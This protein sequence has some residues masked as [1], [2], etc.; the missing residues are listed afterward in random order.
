[1]I[2]EEWKMDLLNRKNRRGSYSQSPLGCQLTRNRRRTSSTSSTPRILLPMMMMMIFFLLSLCTVFVPVSALNPSNVHNTHLLPQNYNIHF[3]N[4]KGLFPSNEGIMSRRPS[5]PS[6]LFQQ[7]EDN[8][9]E[10]DD[11][12]ITRNN[13]KKR[14]F[15]R[16][17]GRSQ[18]WTK[19]LIPTE[20]QP[21]SKNNKDDKFNWVKTILPLALILFLTKGIFFPNISNSNVVYYSSTVYERSYYNQDGQLERIRKENVKSNVPSMITDQ[22][23][24]RGT[25]VEQYQQE[26]ET[27]PV[28]RSLDRE[29]DQLDKEIDSIYGRLY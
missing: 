15:S 20:T 29:L 14:S 19:R 1:M 23:F 11:S 24:L 21:V 10:S 4:G 12:M 3:Q 13:K 22:R 2:P 17:G 9:D 8:E 25:N 6:R 7:M 26:D 16:A 5:I 28:L 27:D 18:S